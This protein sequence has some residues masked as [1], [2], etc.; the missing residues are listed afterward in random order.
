VASTPRTSRFPRWIGDRF[1]DRERVVRRAGD[2]LELAHCRAPRKLRGKWGFRRDHRVPTGCPL[3]S[4]RE[5]A[6]PEPPAGRKCRKWP[7]P[8]ASWRECRFLD[9]DV[10]LVTSRGHCL[11]YVSLH[12]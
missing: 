11:S 7:L 2:S 3:V 6:P 10:M 8:P 5:W 9:R 12:C 1:R 4:T